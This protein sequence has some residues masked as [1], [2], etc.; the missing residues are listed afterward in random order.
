MCTETTKA[1]TIRYP[2]P[3]T[4][5]LQEPPG[6]YGIMVKVRYWGC[7]RLAGNIKNPATEPE[8]ELKPASDMKGRSVHDVSPRVHA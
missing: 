6:L 1:W 8:K 4:T 3:S 2:I 7:L 5:D